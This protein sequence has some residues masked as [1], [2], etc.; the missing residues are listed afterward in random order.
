MTYAPEAAG[1]VEEEN[2]RPEVLDDSSQQLADAGENDETEGYAERGV[3]HRN[4]AAKWRHRND[5]TVTCKH[6]H[7]RARARA[8]QQ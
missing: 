2:E 4:D 1:V 6:T 7:T 3:D 5:V 8:E